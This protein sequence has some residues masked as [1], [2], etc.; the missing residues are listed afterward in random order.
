V[1]TDTT[2]QLAV[3]NLSQSRNCISIVRHLNYGSRT[4]PPN[5]TDP[6]TTTL[7]PYHSHG[8][9]H[10]DTHCWSLCSSLR[11]E[12]AKLTHISLLL[13]LRDDTT[14]RLRQPSI[15]NV[16]GRF[17]G[18]GS[19]TRFRSQHILLARGSSYAALTVAPEQSSER[20]G[21][22]RSTSEVKP[23]RKHS[24]DHHWR[25]R[26]KRAY[27]LCASH[28][29]DKYKLYSQCYNT[30]RRWERVAVVMIR[31]LYNTTRYTLTLE[32]SGE[33]SRQFTRHK[34]ILASSRS[35]ALTCS[36]VHFQ[37]VSCDYAWAIGIVVVKSL[38][39]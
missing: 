29:A 3:H 1:P 39:S 30:I 16:P 2:G 24:F 19:H 12:G 18:A 20:A 31:R 13:Y 6:N 7:P 8:Y 25:S 34:A 11:P 32:L 14:H 22:W 36:D 17:D 15:S 5:P 10:L 37:I 26:E 33:Q 9:W 35:S 28:K 38:L 23:I 21:N 27:E 4:H